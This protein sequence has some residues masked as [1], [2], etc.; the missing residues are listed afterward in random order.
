[1]KIQGQT[2][3]VI[4]DANW[5]GFSFKMPFKTR[6]HTSK[7]WRFVILSFFCVNAQNNFTQKFIQH[8]G[9]NLSRF[10]SCCSFCLKE[11]CQQSNVSFRFLYCIL[12]FL[13]FNKR[14][15]GAFKKS[16]PWTTSH[17]GLK[18]RSETRGPRLCTSEFSSFAFVIGWTTFFH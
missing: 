4:G 12:V 17:V 6:Y 16:K 18:S 14:L 2:Y 3:Q 1:M 7:R 9:R 13:F 8:G 11:L 5:I 10:T 15:N